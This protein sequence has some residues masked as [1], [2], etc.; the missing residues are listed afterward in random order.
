MIP[1]SKYT[2]IN[3]GSSS[4]RALRFLALFSKPLTLFFAHPTAFALENK[5]N[6]PI[7][8]DSGVLQPGTQYSFPTLVSTAHANGVK[9]AVSVGGWSGSIGFSAMVSTA[10]GR[11]EFIK[12]NVQFVQQ[13]GTDGVDLG[14]HF[15]YALCII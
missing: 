1:W 9:V 15:I 10:A 12:W 11:D 14:M 2:H 7:W 13:Y 8:A 3:Y 4:P 6:T 5:G